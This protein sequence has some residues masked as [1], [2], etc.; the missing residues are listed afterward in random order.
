MAFLDDLL[1][2]ARW[3]DQ[4]LGTQQDQHPGI[5]ADESQ[6]SPQL[7]PNLNLYPN[8]LPLWDLLV[9]GPMEP[10]LEYSDP[11]GERCFWSGRD[12]IQ[13][14]LSWDQHNYQQMHNQQVPQHTDPFPEVL[15]ITAAHSVV[16]R[17][18]HSRNTTRYYRSIGGIVKQRPLPAINTS[19][20]PSTPTLA[21]PDTADRLRAMF[22]NLTVW[23]ARRRI[24]D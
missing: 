20:I 16:Y 3:L 13:S 22:G 12:R 1:G 7:H 18:Q 10:V 15:A 4:Y 19:Q 9:R 23:L 21:G 17:Y 6:R 24:Q 5:T 11:P 8:G 14:G 2:N